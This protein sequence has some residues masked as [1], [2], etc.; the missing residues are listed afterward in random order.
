MDAIESLQ[1]SLA[2]KSPDIGKTILT[3]EVDGAQLT[4]E[5]S[6]CCWMNE[7]Y[8]IQVR[9]TMAGGGNAYIHNKA[10]K[11]KD[12][13]LADLQGMLDSV[14]IK[15]CSRCGKPAFDPESVDTNRNGLCEHCFLADLNAEYQKAVQKEKAKVLKLDEKYKK[16]GYKY[17]MN[18]WIHG[19]GDDDIE[20]NKCEVTR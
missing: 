12:T 4:L 19:H 8:G 11:F 6:P 18:A 1:N 13:T 2:S 7:N 10:L 20:D 3:R 9:I 15:K 17:R 16:Q 5:V 14:K